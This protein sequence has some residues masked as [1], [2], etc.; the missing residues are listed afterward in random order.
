MGIISKEGYRG[1]L[2]WA[3]KRMERNK[4]TC[5]TLTPEQHDLLAELCAFRHDLHHN[6]DSAWNEESQNFD[7]FA[8]NIS[9]YSVEDGLSEKIMAALGE[10]PFK[11]IDYPT[12][13]TYELDDLTWEEGY[14]QACDLFAQVNDEIEEF[15]RDIDRDHGTDY[16]PSGTTRLL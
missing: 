8:N 5:T 11:R 2:E 1:K 4:T 13:N 9:E 12:S 15:L 3:A 7:K 6:W 16:A 14:E 10:A